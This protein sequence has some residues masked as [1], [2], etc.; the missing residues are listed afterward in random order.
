MSAECSDPIS[1]RRARH[2]PAQAVRL[3]A[4][5]QTI[6][7]DIIPRLVLAH[8]GRRADG[9]N[10][11]DHVAVEAHDVDDFVQLI[12]GND[13]QA[14]RRCVQ[15]MQDRGIELEAI[16]LDCFSECARRLGRMWDTDEADFTTVTLGLWELH[17]LLGEYSAAFQSAAESEA[18]GRQV[19]LVPMLGEQHTFG[20]SMVAE[21]FRR[22]Q[23]GVLDGPMP[24]VDELLTVVR[25]R[26][27]DVVGISVALEPNLDQLPSLIR[28]IRRASRNR[29]V[30]VMVGGPAFVDR[31]HEVLGVGADASAIDGRE[32]VNVASELLRLL[33]QS[34]SAPHV[35]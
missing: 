29:D 30:R 14:A 2:E 19:L 24:N 3:E 13:Y 27:F 25:E 12:V 16:Y 23:W 20:L 18:E 35:S 7:S 17:R 28:A 1:L 34:Q 31:P 11:V 4:L 26:W 22:A 32:A 21:F 15:R 8:R 9:A 10:A 33:P 6:E 5:L